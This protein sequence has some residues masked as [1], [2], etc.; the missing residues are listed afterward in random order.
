MIIIEWRKFI[1]YFGLSIEADPSRVVKNKRTFFRIGY[2]PSISSG[3]PH[4]ASQQ[5]DKQFNLEPPKLRPCQ[6]TKKVAAK[7]VP[8]ISSAFSDLG[9][10]FYKYISSRITILDGADR[11]GTIDLCYVTQ[12]EQ[13]NTQ[14]NVIE[15]DYRRDMTV[16]T[17]QK[18][19]ENVEA[20]ANIL[21]QLKQRDHINK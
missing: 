12:N 5:L 13:E 10:I 15:G 17:D 11:A 4:I 20:S 9:V 19:Q 1:D 6:P 18:Y 2:I 8:H 7:I 14:N 21:C 3:N 16:D